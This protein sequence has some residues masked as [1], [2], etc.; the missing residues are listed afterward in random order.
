MINELK[1][2][3]ESRM[4]K[5]VEALQSEFIK[6]RTGRANTGILDHIT[7]DYYGNETPLSKV[8]SIN[9]VDARTL[10]ITPWEKSMVAP[11]EKAIRN[12]DLGLNPATAGEVIRVP[13]PPLTEERRKELIK[14][15]RHE[16]ENARVAVRNIRREAN[17]KL[18]ELLKKKEITEDEERR[19]EE[20]HQKLTDHTISEIDKY[21]ADKEKDLMVV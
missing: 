19:G 7:V 4:K 8:A 17:A 10:A 5:S 20:A 16:A 12:S 18:K 14:V 2:S 9:V 1:K 15:V 11:I 3:T 21:L 13:M 6:I